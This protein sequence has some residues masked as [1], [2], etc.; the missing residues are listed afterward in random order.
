[1]KQL[2]LLRHAKT[3]VSSATGED[4]SRELTERGVRNAAS[5]AAH[6]ATQ[7]LPNLVLCSSATRTRQ[8][9]GQLLE[10]WPEAIE[11]RYDDALYL[12][13]AGEILSAIQE[14]PDTV[15][16]LL[17]VGHN[18][19]LHQLAFSLAEEGNKEALQRVATHFPTCALA[20]F[21]VPHS[22]WKEVAPA[23]LELRACLDRHDYS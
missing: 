5:V 22:T 6:I 10:V 19:G 15:E 4:F 1:M 17:V 20:A 8:T 2:L 21:D 12:A 16:T 3:E 7:N 9:T 14:A 13:S 18:P 11:T 23:T